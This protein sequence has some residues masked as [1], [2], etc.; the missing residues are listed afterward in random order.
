MAA[1]SELSCGPSGGEID[2]LKRAPL[3]LRDEEDVTRT[4]SCDAS[5][6]LLC[7]ASYSVHEVP[8]S[9]GIGM[10]AIGLGGGGGSRRVENA[11]PPGSQIVFVSGPWEKRPQFP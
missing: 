11:A 3:R 5:C 9:R 7:S 6:R 2:R 10:S 1:G 8:G 4:V